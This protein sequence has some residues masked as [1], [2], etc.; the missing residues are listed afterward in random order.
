M[1]NIKVH[2][3]F[4]KFKDEESSCMETGNLISL[5]GGICHHVCFVCKFSAPSIFVKHMAGENN[6]ILCAVFCWKL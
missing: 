2:L 3:Y 6:K 5:P 1:S 4:L